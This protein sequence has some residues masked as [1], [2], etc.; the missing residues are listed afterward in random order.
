[1][2]RIVLVLAAACVS[3]QVFG[4]V[5]RLKDGT[6]IEGDVKKGETGWV[7]TLP[8]GG[9]TTVST[10]DVKSIQAGP[11]G[12]GTG[13]PMAGLAS[14]RRST[15][16]AADIAPVIERYKRFVGQVAGTPAEAQAKQDLAAW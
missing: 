3:G 13:E 8:D 12:D 7:V 11:K 6:S 4:D 15:E 1:M 16:N 2:K 5:L 14:L 10:E 9:T